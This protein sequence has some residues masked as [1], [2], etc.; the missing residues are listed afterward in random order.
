MT[1]KV[2]NGSLA[3]VTILTLALTSLTVTKAQADIIEADFAGTITGPA[4]YLDSSGTYYLNTFSTTFTA[5]FMFD[6]ALMST[7]E[8]TAPGI[9][10]LTESGSA[11][12]ASITLASIGGSPSYGNGPLTYS[13]FGLGTLLWQD[14]LGPMLADVQSSGYYNIFVQLDGQGFFQD[15][16]C[17]SLLVPCGRTTATTSNLIDTFPVPAPIVSAGLPGLIL[18]VGIL[19]WMW[20]RK[21]ALSKSPYP[22]SA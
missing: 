21:S 18:V 6:T 3:I 13:I 8:Q 4:P 11:A 22:Q 1:R 14:G 2:T 15:G 10:R 19:S 16:N 12:S 9:Y 5:R 20:R 17:P 7:I